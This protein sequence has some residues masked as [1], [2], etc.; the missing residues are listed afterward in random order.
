MPE[1]DTDAVLILD[2]APWCVMGTALFLLVSTYIFGIL[3]VS[4][5]IGS[6]LGTLCLA[7]IVLSIWRRN[8]TYLLLAISVIAGGVATT[9]NS[10]I[11]TLQ[12]ISVTFLIATLPLVIFKS[13]IIHKWGSR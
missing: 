2:R 12:I 7:L 6:A 4:I 3:Y 13:A 9:T 8:N 10:L 5:A 1:S 11:S